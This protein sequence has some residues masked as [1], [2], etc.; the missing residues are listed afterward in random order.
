MV[1]AI[2]QTEEPLTQ[3]ETQLRID[4][5]RM[6]EFKQWIQDKG[7]KEAINFYAGDSLGAM[8]MGGEGEYK[9]L[10]TMDAKLKYA[11]TLRGPTMQMLDTNRFD[12][13]M[14][15]D[16]FHNIW[17]N[18]KKPWSDEE[19][20]LWHKYKTNLLNE[21]IREENKNIR[22]DTQ[23]GKLAKQH[24]TNVGH[25]SKAKDT[26]NIIS[27]NIR[28]LVPGTTTN[29]VKT[30]TKKETR[31]AVEALEGLL[32]A[33]L[34]INEDGSV[35]F[36][37]VLSSDINEIRRQLFIIKD[38]IVLPAGSGYFAGGEWYKYV[39][40]EADPAIKKMQWFD[41]MVMQILRRGR[42]PMRKIFTQP[43]QPEGEIQEG[44]ENKDPLN[45]F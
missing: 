1:D 34:G 24:N 20:N 3:P 2:A 9:N 5:T 26:Y 43:E 17:A 4:P 18:R 45:I 41:S 23:E 29:K 44:S 12:P 16:K 32:S 27:G 25:F 15:S 11:K 28:N 13:N 6:P 14:T 21:E 10:T 8:I 33:D 40:V 31:E 19:Y 39:D 30:I 22:Q 37:N 36:N 38:D 35:D 42:D 7:K